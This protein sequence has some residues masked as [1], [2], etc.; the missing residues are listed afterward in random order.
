MAFLALQED[1]VSE[2]ITILFYMYYSTS[3]QYADHVKVQMPMQAWAN[4]KKEGQFIVIIF[5]K[6]ALC[7]HLHF[8]CRICNL[9]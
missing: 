7:F 3:R 2:L 5:L 1:W 4:H 8:P 9:G 6:L